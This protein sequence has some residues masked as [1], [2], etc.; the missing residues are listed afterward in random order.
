MHYYYILTG[1]NDDD[2]PSERFLSLYVR[3]EIELSNIQTLPT[4]D[5][6]LARFYRRHYGGSLIAPQPHCSPQKRPCYS[7]YGHCCKLQPCCETNTQKNSLWI[8]FFCRDIIV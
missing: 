8:Y 5:R 6:H 7:A 2:D 4:N 1:G 3:G